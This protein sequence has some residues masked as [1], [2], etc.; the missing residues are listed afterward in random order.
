LNLFCDLETTGLSPTDGAVILSIGMIAD[1]GCFDS[2]AS[3]FEIEICPT[4]EEWA[5]ASEGALKTN[6]MTLEHL[7]ASGVPFENAVLQLGEWLI[8]QS[9]SL[10]TEYIG[11]NPDFDIRFLRYFM[12][13]P[14]A[15]WGFPIDRNPK[16]T[17]TMA[18]SLANKDQVF[19]ATLRSLGTSGRPSFKGSNISKALGLPPEPDLHTAIEGV[20]SLRRNFYALE[21]RLANFS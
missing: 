9:V 12:Y 1:G 19:N 20:R 4:E 7:K 13:A 17:I 3:E 16:D 5:R 14:L 11:Q 6:G 21:K 18:K 10:R 8:R 15:F 2:P